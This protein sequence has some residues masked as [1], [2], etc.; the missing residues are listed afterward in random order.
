MG[1]NVTKLRRATN[2]ANYHPQSVIDMQYAQDVVDAIKRLSMSEMHALQVSGH[3]MNACNFF[4]IINV[5]MNRFA[6]LDE[7]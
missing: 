4:N 2:T 6:A 7:Q 3:S 1:R 5:A